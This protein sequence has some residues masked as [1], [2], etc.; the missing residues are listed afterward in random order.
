MA[1]TVADALE[2]S[3]LKAGEPRV[4]TGAD[5]LDREVRWVHSA[6]IPDIA[7][8]L[9]GGEL[10]L[11]AGLGIGEGAGQQR[12][13]VRG[14]AAAGSSALVIEESGRRF[15]AVPKT[16]VNEATRCG[17]PVVALANEV[18]FAAVSAQV[19]EILTEQ[20]LHTLRQEREVESIF[21]SLLLGGADHLEIMETL[22]S[23]TDSTVVLENIA[24]R[25]TAYHT[26]DG[27]SFDVDSWDR[28]ARVLHGTH[29]TCVRRPVLMRG[30]PWG[31]V[32]VIDGQSNSS[33]F[34]AD[35]AAERAAVAVAISLLTD[36]SLQARDDQRSTALM[37]HL[38]LGELSGP[39]FI[40]QAGRLGYHLG[41]GEVFVIVANKSPHDDAA[42]RAR[43]VFDPEA[44]SAD[45]EDYVV[46]VAVDSARTRLMT[47]L[48]DDD[49]FRGGGASRSVA[50]QMIATAVTQAKNAAAVARSSGR[51]L[52]F[53]DLG[54]E[55][56]LVTLAQGPELA[57]FVEDELGPLLTYDARSSTPL[58]PTLKAFLSVDGRKS[59]AAEKL[60]VQRRTLY[61]RLERISTILGRSLEEPDNRQR[62]LLAVKGLD[63]LQD[64]ALHT[65]PRRIPRR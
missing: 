63:L 33:Q 4:L 57:S 6:E 65:Q 37:T 34:A 15:D 19:H 27:A 22:A 31:W 18:P 25:L 17:L 60:F 55:R 48:R 16:V 12:A 54:V 1:F 35:F 3:T 28:H 9:T 29:T 52:H 14:I 36:R 21:S 24:H 30:Q 43:R 58:L 13:Y 62:L 49:A 47:R 8:F 42:P 20:R 41:T 2:I 64:S 50:P 45:M 5:G 7:K 53:D 44:I 59:E 11:T 39:D 56:I 46:T 10:L 61:N 23:L 38:M 40:H 26:P 51:V 32:H